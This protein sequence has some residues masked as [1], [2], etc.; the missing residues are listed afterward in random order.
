MVWE[1][2][3][4]FAGMT[5]SSQYNE[6]VGVALPKVTLTPTHTP[7][8]YIS[9]TVILAKAG[10]AI[11]TTKFVENLEKEFLNNASYIVSLTSY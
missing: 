10:I 5:G 4:A 1:A 11:L 9:K 6:C 3:P 8:I 7:P 2:I